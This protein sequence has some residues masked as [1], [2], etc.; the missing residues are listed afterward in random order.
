[1]Q[2]TKQKQMLAGMPIMGVNVW[3]EKTMNTEQW[4]INA[5]L[6][7]IYM[8]RMQHHVVP[9]ANRNFHTNPKI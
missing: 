9:G 8:G 5:L 6:V 1:M 7:L 2:K 3:C 4:N